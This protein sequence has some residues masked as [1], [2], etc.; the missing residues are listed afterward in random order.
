MYNVMYNVCSNS[1][2]YVMFVET[3]WIIKKLTYKDKKYKFKKY[4]INFSFSLSLIFFVE[5]Y[6]DKFLFIYN[7]NT[8]CRW[9]V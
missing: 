2:K 5:R 9:R 8:L 7:S 6:H 1:A 4:T 3:L